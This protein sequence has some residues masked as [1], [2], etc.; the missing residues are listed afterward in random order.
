MLPLK[1]KYSNTSL[2]T[3]VINT[4]QPCWKFCYKLNKI[5]QIFFFLILKIFL[6]CTFWHEHFSSDNSSE[7]LLTENPEKLG[8]KISVFCYQKTLLSS[9][10]D[11]SNAVLTTLSENLKPFAPSPK[12]LQQK[13]FENT[14]KVVLWTRRVLFRQ[15]CRYFLSQV[16]GKTF[17]I[18][19]LFK[20]NLSSNPSG[21]H[22]DGNSKNLQIFYLK[23]YE[24]IILFCCVKEYLFLNNSFFDTQNALFTALSEKFAKDP[25]FFVF[26]FSFQPHISH[27]SFQK[28]K[29]VFF[30][31]SIG[32]VKRYLDNPIKDP[33]PWFS[34]VFRSTSEENFI[35]S[36]FQNNT[37]VLSLDKK[38]FFWQPWKIFPGK[39]VKFFRSL[40]R[41]HKASCFLVKDSWKFPL[42]F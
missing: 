41:K 11:N 17:E 16:W 39:N 22:V 13:I 21:G 35:N 9:P 42:D 30:S 18:K 38:R 5:L 36:V 25:K 24:R 23:P 1:E 4:L 3:K 31:C 26:L 29:T 34:N 40:S 32:H 15:C 27:F 10:H 19:F 8:F 33:L 2:W 12:D 6:N 14:V 28:K 37:H 20:K 7:T